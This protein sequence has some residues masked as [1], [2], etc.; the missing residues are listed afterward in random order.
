[1]SAVGIL[2]SLLSSS[3]FALFPPYVLWLTPL[4]GVQI[5]VWRVLWILPGLV[6][7]LWLMGEGAALRLALRR[8]QQEPRLLLALLLSA[9]LLAAQWLV[10]I[11]APLVGRTLDVALG[12]FLLPLVMVLAGRLFYGER[13]LPLQQL[14]LGL[15]ALGVLHECLLSQAMSIYTLI[16]AAGYVPYFMLRRWMQLPALTGLLLEVLLMLPPALLYLWLDA[17]PLPS[18]QPMLWWLLAGLGLLSALAFAALLGANQRLSLGLLGIF[19]Y[20]E[21][22]LIF[23][24]ALF[25]LGEP[26]QREQL[27][28]YVPI[29]LAILL[30]VADS[31][32]RLRRPV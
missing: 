23:L 24:V 28:T 17:R 11:L 3:L 4:D 31:L 20:L 26:F 6:L 15:A 1:M 9:C 25:W 16:S 8:L 5:T 2:L 7:L 21:P 19:S 27:P 10:F 14:A 32:W 22:A 13:L 30:V 29:W 12:Y 18:G